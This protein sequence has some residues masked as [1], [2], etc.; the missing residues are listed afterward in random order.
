M[1][2][3]TNNIQPA[4]GQALTIKDE[5]GTASITVAT[6][7]EATFAENIIIG[8]AGKGI[9]FQDTD[10][11]NDSSTNNEAYTLDSYETG[12]FTPVARDESGSANKYGTYTKIG[13]VCHFKIH[14]NTM[15]CSNGSNEF[16]ITGLPF[17][18]ESNANEASVTVG[19]L[20]FVANDIT[21]TA[22]QL[23]AKVGQNGTT[24]F[25]Y[26]G[27]DDGAYSIALNSNFDHANASISLTGTYQTA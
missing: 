15:G 24:L 13:N 19:P 20:Y 11:T 5:G 25:F 1:S 7:G 8:T 26:W 16:N 23:G 6:N 17:T 4:S 10:A 21:S 9:T 18:S 3:I 22:M 12:T 2:V 14:I 27:V